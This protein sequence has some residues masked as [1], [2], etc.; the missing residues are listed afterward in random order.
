MDSLDAQKVQ[1]LFSYLL[2]HAGQPHHREKLAG[3]LWAEQSA[4]QSKNYLRRTLWQ[5][6]SALKE[7]SEE[8]PFL[9]VEADW[10]RLDCSD[11]LWV[12]TAVFEL[13][14]ARTNGKQGEGLD[15]TAVHALVEAV[16]IYRGELLEGWYQNWCL[17]E[18]ERFRQ[19]LLMM[20]D[21]LMA[22]GEANGAYEAAITYGMEILRHDLARE[23][24]HRQLMRLHYLVGDRTGAL[25][26]YE[27]CKAILQEELGV[28]PAAA[29]EQ[30]HS[31]IEADN[32]PLYLSGVNHSASLQ[33]TLWR[34]QRVDAILQQTRQEIQHEIQRVESSL[35]QATQTSA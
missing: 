28:A 10:I 6:Q 27:R 31:Q 23:R 4:V 29:T 3:L 33:D 1:E 5:L 19:M 8:A 35:T 21:K 17:F 30:L 7:V 11:C 20:L 13:A 32:L 14:F 22:Y 25:R 26:Q 34:L 9:Q 18:R 12:D 2:L 15:E 24:T 16:Q